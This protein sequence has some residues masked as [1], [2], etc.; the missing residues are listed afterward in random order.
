MICLISLLRSS[1]APKRELGS[2]RRTVFPGGAFT[3]R[4]SLSSRGARRAPKGVS[5]P[6][7]AREVSKRPLLRELE[8]L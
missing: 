3:Q 4:K 7:G 1:S 6:E 5:A 8:E 2:S